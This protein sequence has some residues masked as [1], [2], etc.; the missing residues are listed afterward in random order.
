MTLRVWKRP[1]PGWAYEGPGESGEAICLASQQRIEEIAAR[2]LGRQ[3]GGD[4]Q[5]FP[6]CQGV[7]VP[8]SLWIQALERCGLPVLSRPLRVHP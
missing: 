2:T 5:G 7:S 6:T 1:G 3:E 8:R 4:G